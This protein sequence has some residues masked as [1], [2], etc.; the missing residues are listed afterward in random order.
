[1]IEEWIGH[2][3]RFAID[4]NKRLDADFLALGDLP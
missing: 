3:A 1:M 4:E 2:I